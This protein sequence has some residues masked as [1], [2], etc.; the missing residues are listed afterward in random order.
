M[1]KPTTKTSPTRGLG[2]PAYSLPPCAGYPDCA[3]KRIGF[4]DVC[5]DCGKTSASPRRPHLSVEQL[6]DKLHA[7]GVEIIV[8][9][10]KP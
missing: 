3:H 4:G 2:L 5:L 6:F 10:V 1:D 9:Q 7:A 8:N